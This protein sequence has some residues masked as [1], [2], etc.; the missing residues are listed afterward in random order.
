MFK[1]SSLGPQV[2]EE[3]KPLVELTSSSLTS[4]NCSNGKS[5]ASATAAESSAAANGTDI[6][7]CHTGSSLNINPFLSPVESPNNEST[8]LTPIDTNFSHSNDHSIG[9]HHCNGN[10][11][12]N[13]NNCYTTNYSNSI[14]NDTSDLSQV[15]DSS[16][17]YSIPLHH[18]T[19][20][21]NINP[22]PTVSSTCSPASA[23]TASPSSSASANYHAT[24]LMPHVTF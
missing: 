2:V 4:R 8:C 23:V 13:G 12:N 1:Q 18:A 11:S 9:Y 22:P 15:N 14:V 17:H 19:A 6:N 3:C 10:S 5:G 21:H 20:A 7:S 24:S 16:C